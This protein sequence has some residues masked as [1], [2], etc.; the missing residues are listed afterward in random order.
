MKEILL[1]TKDNFEIYGNYLYEKES[2]IAGLLLH[3]M[4]AT[5]ESYLDFQ[6]KLGENKISSLALD[7]RGHGKSL[8]KQNGNLLSYQNFTDKDHQKKIYDLDAGVEF[9]I[10]NGFLKDK[11]FL[12]GAS[13]GANLALWYASQNP[14]I[15]AI[16]LLSPG[17]NYRGITT[18]DKLASLKENQSVFLYAGGALD[19]Y[20]NETVKEL[21]NTKTKANIHTVIFEDAEHGTSIF[22]SH[23]EFMQDIINWLISIYR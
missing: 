10:K 20:S 17:L 23:P 2:S 4:P 14:E 5:K 6:N 21:A 8:I 15:K 13:I 12:V 19:S 22:K 1:K 11:I 9:L 16:V 18:K 3:M 7:L